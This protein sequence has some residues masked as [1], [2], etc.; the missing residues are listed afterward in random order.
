MNWAGSSR[1]SCSINEVF[2]PR[3]TISSNMPSFRILPTSRYYEVQDSSI[4]SVLPRY[5]R[6]SSQ[7]LLRQNPSRWHITILRQVSL[8][9]LL[10][11]GTKLVNELASAQ[12]IWKRLRISPKG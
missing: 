9:R 11:I 3:H 10:A 12:R 1:Q 2:H 4:T 6:N 5:W 8:N 7:R